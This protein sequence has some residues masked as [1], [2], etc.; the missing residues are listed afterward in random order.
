MP[1]KEVSGVGTLPLDEKV[2]VKLNGKTSEMEFSSSG[3]NLLRG[4]VKI[5]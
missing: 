2:S 1:S 5:D 4:P 3:K